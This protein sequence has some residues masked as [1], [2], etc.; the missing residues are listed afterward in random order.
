V[1][2]RAC[3]QCSMPGCDMLLCLMLCLPVSPAAA[4]VTDLILGTGGPSSSG[5]EAD[6]SGVYG[7]GGG[8]RGVVVVGILIV[9]YKPHIHE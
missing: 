3:V 1:Y 2:A 7:K 9:G 8:V 4:K 5:T 6:T